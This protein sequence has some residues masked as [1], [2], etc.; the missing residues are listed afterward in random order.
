MS[1]DLQLMVLNVLCW[2]YELCVV[3]CVNRLQ[4]CLLFEPMYQDV[5]RHKVIEIQLFFT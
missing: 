4:M 5:E 2:L 1:D 3:P